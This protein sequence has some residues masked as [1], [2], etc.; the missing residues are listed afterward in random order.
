MLSDASCLE[1]Y[2]QAVPLGWF[3]FHS[4]VKEMVHEAN[5]SGASG[6]R[7][8]G[9]RRIS[10]KEAEQLATDACQISS[11]TE[12]QRM[13]QEFH[14]VG[15]LMWHDRPGTR[16]LVVLD[17]QWMI[18][19]MTELLCRRSLEAKYDAS[20]DK[21]DAWTELRIRGRFSIDLLPEL[22]PTLEPWE[23]QSVLKYMVG[24]GHCCLMHDAE[25]SG[26]KWIAQSCSSPR[27]CH[28][29]NRLRNLPWEHQLNC[30]QIAGVLRHLPL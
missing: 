7:G 6:A 25:R 2:G 5:S 4:I 15:F 28:C 29:A 17:V 12:I 11:A 21:K 9:R 22:W 26:G 3:K 8:V 27:C 19:R 23:R 1:R 10:Y 13:L 20:V 18:D 30:R 14:D 16:D 24:F